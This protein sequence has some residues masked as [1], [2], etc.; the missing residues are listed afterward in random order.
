M[1]APLTAREIQAAFEKGRRVDSEMADL[2]LRAMPTFFAEHPGWLTLPCNAASIC[3]LHIALLLRCEDDGTMD[4]M[5]FDNS[6]RLQEIFAANVRHSVILGASIVDAARSARE[7]GVHGT[8]IR[9]LDQKICA[10]RE[11]DTAAEQALFAVKSASPR[12]ISLI[13]RGELTFRAVLDRSPHLL[14][15]RWH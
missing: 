2:L 6:E 14:L 1:T 12:V 4:K 5:I 13:A 15:L 11:L 10:Y 9:K 3:E 8:V 7:S